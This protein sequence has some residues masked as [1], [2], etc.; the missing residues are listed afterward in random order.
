MFYLCFWKNFVHNF[1]RTLPRMFSVS[2][3]LFDSLIQYYTEEK[4]RRFS[5]SSQVLQQS[6][7]L[8]FFTEM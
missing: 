8:F 2:W 5:G 7:F 6:V 3:I 1:E 4:A